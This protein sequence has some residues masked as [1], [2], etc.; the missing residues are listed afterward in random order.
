MPDQISRLNAALEGRYRIE[1]EL[2]AGGMATVYLAEDLRHQRKVAVKVLRPELAAVVGADRFL[3]E[4]KTTANL[5]HPHIL[6]LFDS[7]EADHFLYYVMPYVEGETLADR[8]RREKQLPVDEALGIATA[9]AHALQTAH[10]Q[11]VIH[12]DIKPGNILLSRGQALVADFGIAIAVGSAGGGRLTET[13][14]S[15]GTPFYMSPEQA[16]GDQ[17]V[18]PASDIYALGCVLYEML[19]GDPPYG[20]ST[21]Q[22]VL[23]KIIQGVPVSAT[24]ARKAVPR[25]IDAAIRKALEKLPADRFARA[26]DLAKA[27]ADPTFRHGEAEAG[28][29]PERAGV[30]KPLALAGGVTTLALAGVLAWVLSRPVPSLPVERFESPFK[31]DQEPVAF[32]LGGFRLS[33][34]GS[35]LVYRGPG[36]DGQ[37]DQL[38]VRRWEDPEAVPVRGS[39][40]AAVPSVSPDGRELAF[41]VDGEVRALALEG[42]PTRVLASNVDVPRWLADGNVYMHT[43]A[44]DAVRVPAAGGTVDT[45]SLKAEGEG[46]RFIFELL[47]GGDGALML[48]QRTNLEFEIHAFDLGTGESR[49]LAAGNSVAYSTSGHLVYLTEGA[50]VAAPFDPRAMELLG[51][52]VPLIDGVQ[53]FSFSDNGRLVYATGAPAEGAN[54]ELVWLSRSGAASRVDS[55]WVFDPGG[56]NFGWALSPDGSRIAVRT[57]GS[58]GNQDIW[59]KELPAGPLRRLTFDANEQRVPFWTPDGTRVMYFTTP[60][61]GSGAGDLWWSRSDG[62]GQ[63]ERILEA[64]PGFAQGTWSP[65]GSTLVLRTAVLGTQG[66]RPGGRD[67]MRFRPGSDSAAVPILATAEYAEFDP[68]VSPNGRWLAYASNETGR[69]EIFVRPFPDVEAGKFQVSTNGGFAPLWSKAAPELFYVDGAGDLVVARFDERTGFRVM[70]TERLFTLP[71]EVFQAGGSNWIDVAPDGQRFLVGR[72]LNTGAD[73]DEENQARLVLVQNFVEELRRRVPR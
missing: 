17:V 65:D 34:D 40:N 66:G 39:T 61:A 7:G 44:G 68:K 35:M 32:G 31:A 19:V 1:R 37:G 49:F 22:A 25:N 15:L 43:V 71:S 58:D 18:G 41:F 30:W 56:G 46:R 11:G 59:I 70:S 63:P 36:P 60:E 5:Q 27:L 28:I 51:P 21:A 54:S 2:G 8:L 72:T 14:L 55:G 33:S 62:T 4:I 42:G 26:D 20:G 47:P 38:W 16:T 23:G 24:A 10:D 73:A 3:S 9:V 45:V 48:I 29:A 64:T 53:A 50:L 13:G 52:A 67:L 12:R 69:D 57:R 6:P